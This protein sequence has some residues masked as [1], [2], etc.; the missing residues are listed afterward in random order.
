M[1]EEVVS[2]IDERHSLIVSTCVGVEALAHNLAATAEAF[3]VDLG[4]EIEELTVC[5]FFV[6]QAHTLNSGEEI[7]GELG[8]FSFEAPVVDFSAE[9]VACCIAG[10]KEEYVAFVEAGKTAE[11]LKVL[12]S[13]CIAKPENAGSVED[14]CAGNLEF[15]AV[16]GYFRE[17][18]HRLKVELLFEC[19]L[20]NKLWPTKHNAQH[21]AYSRKNVQRENGSGDGED[22][23]D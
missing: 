12:S 16:D 9:L 23:R 21:I 2:F 3:R 4:I 22:G 18:F 20:Y 11:R 14:G 13:P 8:D 7:R 5:G 15:K 19:C 1:Q 6:A 17:H 10:D